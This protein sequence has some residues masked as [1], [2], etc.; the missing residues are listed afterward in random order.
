MSIFDPNA[1]LEVTVNE[2]N[3]R[4]PPIPTENP[5]TS[6]GLYTAVIGEIKMAGGQKKDGGNWLQAI[7]PLV[8]EIPPQLRDSLKL[9]PTFTLTD[10]AFIDITDQGLIDNAPGKNR[11]QKNYREATGTNAAGLA[12]SWKQLQGKVVKVKVSH[13]M[14]E[15]FPQER[16]AAVLKA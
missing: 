9:Q 3:E 5:A 13:E 1:F 4:R 15:G 12:W 2:V 11:S 16:V 8:L 7:V 10:R 6:D 14:Y